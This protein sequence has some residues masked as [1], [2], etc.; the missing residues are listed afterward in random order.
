MKNK[1]Y[2]KYRWFS[3]VREID[4]FNKYFLFNYDLFNGVKP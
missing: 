2:F 1:I 3:Q 4:L